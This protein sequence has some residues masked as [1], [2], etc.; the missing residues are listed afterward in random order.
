MNNITGPPVEGDNFFGREREIA[1]AWGRI[2]SGNNII[3]PSP[4]RVGKTSFALK[5][6]DIAEK[7]KWNTIS[8]N[9]EKITSE[10]EFI[11]K[12]VN[13][14]KKLSWWSNVSDKMSDFLD[15]LKKLKPSVEY[16][17]V[18]MQLEWA[19]QK[20]DI[21]RRLAELLNHNEP[22]LIFFDELTVLLNVILESDKDGKKHVSS[23][24]HWLRSNRIV[25]GSKIRWVYCS[26]VG[27]ENFTHEHGISDTINDIS[28][29]FLKPFS[30][31]E[32]IAMLKKL[33]KD[34]LPITDKIADE[35][36][37]KLD[38]CLPFF[39]QVIFDKMNYLVAIEGEPINTELVYKAY[40]QINNEN[41]F[42]TWIERIE[43]Q[44]HS[45]KL[46]V[47]AILKHVC[48]AVGG[49]SRANLIN[50]VVAT[51]LDGNEAEEMVRKLIYMLKNDGYLVEDDG[52]YKFRSPLL[53]DFW[54]NRFVR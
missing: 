24:L 11:E 30:R 54:F 43:K 10:H 4:R 45:N 46:S 38:Y 32:S 40:E 47:F 16:A 28:G 41:H 9:L 35:V 5:L 20:M 48:Q 34:K 13:E 19:E 25:S 29:Y 42:N 12:L 52:L 15:T 37:N 17:G 31:E 49:A 7:K 50:V 21:Y 18:K 8:I 51:G 1:Y 23:F 14:L 44:Y 33:S 36:V 26:S 53:R 39:L 3:L 6:V 22:T 27:I 2:S